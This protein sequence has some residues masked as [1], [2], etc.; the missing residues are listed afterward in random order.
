MNKTQTSILNVY[1]SFFRV[2]DPQIGR[3]WQVDPNPQDFESMYA[4]MGNNPILYCD[5]LGDVY[6]VEGIK[7]DKE[8]Y[9][10]YLNNTTGN[11]YKFSKD[12]NLVRTNKK[13][14]TKTTDKIS[15]TLSKKIEEV[16]K[17]K[18]T[19]SFTLV[20]DEKSNGE[21]MIDQF[22]SGKVDMNDLAK[23]AEKSD[24]LLAGVLGHFAEESMQVPD[25]SKR[26]HNNYHEPHEAGKKNGRTNCY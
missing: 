8:T 16:I 1:E 18:E 15:G 2:H 12:G 11:S 3:W 5:K 19:V 6:H 20:N 4:C 26:N 21:V 9:L 14:N 17:N 13:L 10:Q 24:A 23:I 22:S 7:E 25:I